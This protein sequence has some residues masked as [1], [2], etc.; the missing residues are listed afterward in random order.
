MFTVDVKQ[1]CKNNIKMSLGHHKWL[2]K[3]HFPPGPVFRWQS[4]SL[5][6]LWYYG[7]P[8]LL[9]SSCSFTYLSR[10]EVP[11]VLHGKCCFFY[12]L[13]QVIIQKWGSI[14][15]EM[16]PWDNK[17]YFNHQDHQFIT[18][19]LLAT[20]VY[21]CHNMGSLLIYSFICCVDQTV[22][23]KQAEHYTPVHHFIT[24]KKF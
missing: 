12:Y 5:A 1:Q 14:Y 8:L 23:V 16:R 21:S 20:Q 18:Q 13:T 2:R 4:P 10:S 19:G 9:S 6:T 24:W 22:H 11:H 15:P 7:S 17:N 3:D